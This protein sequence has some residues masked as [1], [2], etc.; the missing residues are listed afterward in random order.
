MC[1]N[2]HV[3]RKIDELEAQQAA[4]KALNA[5]QL[6]TIGEKRVLT[7]L[8]DE[9]DKLGRQLEEALRADLA[10]AEARGAAKARAAAEAERAREEAARP[11][12]PPS[13]EEVTARVLDAL[14]PALYFSATLD[15]PDPS[16]R[17][18]EAKAAL[19]HDANLGDDEVGGCG[20]LTDADLEAIAS[21][22]RLVLSRQHGELSSH[23]E[24]MDRCRDYCRAYLEASADKL[25]G[26]RAGVT[27]ARIR[28]MVGRLLASDYFTVK[29]ELRPRDV[30][31][32]AA[33][34]RPPPFPPGKARRCR[35]A[36]TSLHP[37]LTR[38]FLQLPEGTVLP[39]M[40]TH[41][42]LQADL[43]VAGPE[44]GSDTGRAPPAPPAGF[45]MF[46]FPPR[47]SPPVP[48][49]PLQA[50]A[51]FSQAVFGGGLANHPFAPAPFAAPVA[52]AGANQPPQHTQQQQPAA[53][54][55]GSGSP[56]E[57]ASPGLMAPADFAVPRGAKAPPPPPPR[58]QQGEPGPGRQGPAVGRGFPG[59]GRT[60]GR[61]R[62]GWG[63]SDSQQGSRP[64]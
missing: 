53:S 50:P 14:V 11:P 6:G 39:G 5:E 2:S 59:R 23:Q 64:F 47:H 48:H 13:E 35:M 51:G 10:E 62:G 61:G 22:G 12:P 26:S 54:L 55:Q 3:F 46:G 25:P 38:A 63:S 37:C 36:C 43:S 21:F 58:Q 56:E 52:G 57:G 42:F 33:P 16:L 28:G 19:S 9:L 34:A 32:A 49:V 29:P 44:A 7:A 1:G 40:P 45:P 41:A 24:S 18:S 60:G 27:F 20:P 31:P 8:V 15:A 17:L 30:P 4:G